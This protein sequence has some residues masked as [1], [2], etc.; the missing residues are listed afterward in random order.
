MLQI[1]KANWFV[2]LLYRIRNF[3]LKTD[4]S[5]KSQMAFWLK[6]RN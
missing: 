3:T 4:C 6:M 2:S 5:R 1:S